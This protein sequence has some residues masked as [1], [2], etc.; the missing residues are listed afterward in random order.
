[1]PTEVWEYTPTGGEWWNRYADQPPVPPYPHKQAKLPLRVG[2]LAMLALIACAM[3][4]FAHQARE[5]R[6]H[7]ATVAPAP[8]YTSFYNCKLIAPGI[9]PAQRDGDPTHTQFY[10]YNYTVCDGVQVTLWSAIR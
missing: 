9:Q 5:Q 10:N 7:A 1:M 2:D 6:V 8:K 4:W 3:L